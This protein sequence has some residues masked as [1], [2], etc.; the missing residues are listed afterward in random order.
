MRE[1]IE[2]L[3]DILQA[4]EAI[5]R[6]QHVD[7]ETFEQDDMLQVWF[8]HHLRIIGEAA[9]TLPEDVR[10]TAPEVP[11]KQIIA[12]RNILV[13]SYFEIDTDIV[14]NTVQQHIPTLKASIEAL[15]RRLQGA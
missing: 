15:L 4:I 3:Y 10:A 8:V 7:R 12:M 6:F 5:E 2:R 11:W 9:R 1:P 13:H 14:W